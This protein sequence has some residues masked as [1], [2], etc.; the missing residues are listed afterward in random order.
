MVESD[1]YGYQLNRGTF[2]TASIVN[3]TP[4]ALP[5]KVF[6]EVEL[7]S[8]KHGLHPQTEQTEKRE[9]AEY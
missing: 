4:P 6:S 9:K 1:V 5:V 2:M 8:R 7:K 3:L